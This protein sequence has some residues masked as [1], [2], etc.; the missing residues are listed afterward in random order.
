LKHYFAKQDT[1]VLMLDDLTTELNDK[2][3]H[4]V[5]PSEPPSGTCSPR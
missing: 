3:V 5:A 2:T 4:S 1:T